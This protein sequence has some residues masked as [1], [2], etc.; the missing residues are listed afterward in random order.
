MANMQFITDDLDIQ[1]KHIVSFYSDAL[2]E[3]KIQYTELFK[4]FSGGEYEDVYHEKKEKSIEVLDD[5][6]K[7]EGSAVP[8]IGFVY[9]NKAKWTRNTYGSGFMYTSDFKQYNRWDLVAELTKYNAKLAK[10]DID[11]QISSLINNADNTTNVGYDELALYSTAHKLISSGGTVGN[12]P[13]AGV[14]LSL[15]TYEDALNYLRVYKDSR[16][17]IT[18]KKAE[19]L[20]VYPTQARYVWQMTHGTNVP[21]E[22][23]HTEHWPD[24]KNIQVVLYERQT[25]PDQWTIFGEKND[26]AFGLFYVI[27]QNPNVEVNPQVDASRNVLVNAH[28][29]YK[30]GIENPRLLYGSMGG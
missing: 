29:A 23:T 17:R 2:D 5:L 8:M 16:G 4:Q 19:K 10:E 18:A 14:D 7:P 21:F 6:K 28:W 13:G 22:A 3:V 26:P 30:Y 9:G 27:T 15:S 24:F 11:I 1:K 25:D 12:T 20:L